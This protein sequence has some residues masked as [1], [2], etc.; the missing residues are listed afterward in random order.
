MHK[1]LNSVKFILLLF[2]IVGR[3]L[4]HWPYESGKIDC[5]VERLG[6]SVVCKVIH[7]NYTQSKA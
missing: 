1:I 3:Q 6:F 2:Q 4:A 5:R 7:M